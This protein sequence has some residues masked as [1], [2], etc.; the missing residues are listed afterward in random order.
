MQTA[1][2]LPAEEGLRTALPLQGSEAKLYEALREAVPIVDAAIQKI[3]RLMGHFLYCSDDPA[4]QE[5]L[6]EFARQ[7]KVGATGQGLNTFIL[8]YLDSLL[9]Y[10][11]AV[12]E[13]VLAPGGQHIAAL[14]NPGLAHIEIMPGATP[15]EAR[16]M[17]RSEGFALS[18][19]PYPELIL[20][21]ALSPGPGSVTGNSILK[22]LPSV[23]EVLLKIYNSIGQN[24]DRVA[25][26]RFAVTCKPGTNAD[27]AYAKDIAREIASEWSQAMT[28]CQ[29]GQVR[30]F[31]AV[32]DV[33]IKVIGADNQTLDTEI[34]VRQML[35]EIVAKLGLPP[36]LL[37][38]SWSTTERMSRQQADILTSE[39]ESY[40]AI[41]GPVLLKIAGLFLRLGGH[42]GRV[43]VE[44]D[45][46]SL[47]DE[48][49]LANAR[50]TNARAAA[51]EQG[52]RAKE[53]PP[54]AGSFS[55]GGQAQ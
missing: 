39:L 51:L 23:C 36:F 49:E 1:R 29:N 22:G 12:G 15:L 28:S 16:I 46:I 41:I 32:G 31:V 20:F 25:N 3:L 13:M 30:D 19:V 40:R 21:S 45:N 26:V 48:T 17:V 27:R 38:L 2:H 33:D 52:I 43:W 50:L 53:S 24:F 10:G 55:G 18:P 8:T 14:Y 47:L 7:V 42:R 44:W 9:T 34:P 6:R 5:A 11:N 37:G 35:E 54:S 4:T